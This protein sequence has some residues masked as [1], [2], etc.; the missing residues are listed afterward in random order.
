MAY[1]CDTSVD[2]PP[3]LDLVIVVRKLMNMFSIDFPSVHIGRD[4]NF[5]IEMELGIK[6]IFVPHDTMASIELKVIE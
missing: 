4:I 6:P 1:V 2:S 3:P 5:S